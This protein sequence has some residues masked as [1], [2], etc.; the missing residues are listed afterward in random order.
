MISP[1]GDCHNTQSTLLLQYLLSSYITS[2]KQYFSL[3][4]QVT[5]DYDAVV[6]DVLRV[7]AEDIAVSNLEH[8]WNPLSNYIFLFSGQF[9]LEVEC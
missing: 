4:E 5:K 1:L 7:N 8:F 9:W 3:Q 2:I 6:F